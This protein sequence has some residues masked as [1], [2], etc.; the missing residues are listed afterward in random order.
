MAGPKMRNPVEATMQ[1]RR[2]VL[3]GVLSIA[4]LSLAA[5]TLAGGKEPPPPPQLQ[6]VT[7]APVLQREV[8]EWDEFTGRLEAVDAVE[9]RPRVSG[10]IT[11]V[12]F[13]EGKEVK[14]GEVLF[15][16]DPRP[17]QAELARAEAE[18]ER[19]RSAASL[20]A[21]EV[22]RAGKLVDAQAISREEYEGRTSAEAQGGATVRAAEA[23][24]RT[25]RLNLDW[26]RVRAPI[27]GR[28]S[29]AMVTP[30]N[31][32]EAG[33]PAAT[34]L[35]TVVSLDP[36]YVYFDSDEQTY[37]RY[38]G[39]ARGH[40][41]NWRD[42]RLPVY[43]GLANEEGF[44]HEGR[45]DFVDNQVDPNTG[46]I[47]TR[48]VFSNRS[49]ALTPGLFARVKLVGTQKTKALLVRDAAIGTDQDRKF[50][51]VVGPGDTL[52]YRPIVPGR[53]NDGLRIVNSG[54][55]AGDRVV[56]NG[57]MRVR[58]GM[59]VAPTLTAMVPDST[60]PDSTTPAAER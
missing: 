57:L 59:Q 43:L 22:A 44:P 51:L 10:Y 35:T 5:L 29:N 17:Y 60:V 30:G 7:V 39:R 40:G 14:K 25:A 37:L 9:I 53:L 38:A 28:V 13:D 8:S 47:R 34:L 56:V 46:T 11:R 15:E 6:A 49:R 36:M 33:P 27:S 12:A 4:L 1:T 32:V 24:V 55:Q 45:L 50:V 41:G 31:L 19:A 42:T 2:L 52:A 26:T 3:P 20:A 23:A 48:A 54:L 18:L 58:P 16:I 21:S